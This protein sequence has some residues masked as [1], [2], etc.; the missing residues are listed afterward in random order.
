M[1]NESRQSRPRVVGYTRVSTSEQAREGVSLTAQAEK[2]R[3]FTRLHDLDLVASFEDAGVS[4][5]SLDRPALRDAR[6]MLDSGAAD[7]LVIF[8]LDRLTR[9]M[10]D[11]QTLIDNHFG[12]AGGKSL[13][14]VSDHIDTR[15][16][17]GMLFLNIMMTVAQWEREVILERVR[18]AVAFKKK[19]GQRLSRTAPYG[20]VIVEDGL[21]S[22]T[23]NAMTM[24]DAATERE[25]LEAIIGGRDRGDSL[26]AI[27]ARLD[28]A[29][30]PT[31]S[32]RPWSHTTVRKLILSG[33]FARP[34]GIFNQA[35]STPTSG[36]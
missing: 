32:G 15:S 23:G 2:I 18:G 21:V 29:G 20:K 24:A 22:R 3:E 6:A 12:E 17:T 30:V 5:K 13:G 26:R 4:A 7:G 35:K 19:Q 14:S 10:R 36:D 25:A 9:S 33:R 16:A 11:W 34:G 28:A 27:A 31:R 1:G 8:K